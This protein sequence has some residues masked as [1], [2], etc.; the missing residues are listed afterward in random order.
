MKI[1]IANDII[2]FLIN[3]LRFMIYI[4]SF[5]LYLG[6]LIVIYY[7]KFRLTLFPSSLLSSEDR[8]NSI[9]SFPR[10]RSFNL[11]E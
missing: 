9:N 5:F 10:L 3:D 11:S 4:T 2:C 8:L 1:T 6:R 7:N